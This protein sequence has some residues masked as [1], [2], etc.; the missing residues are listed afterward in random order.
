MFR[1]C[2]CG[3]T[4]NTKEEL[5]LFTKDKK[6]KYGRSNFCNTCAAAKRKK[7]VANNRNAVNRDQQDRKQN[8]KR[9]AIELKGSMCKH[10]GLEYDYTNAAVFDLH[11]LNPNEKEYKPSSLFRMSWE[12]IEKELNKCILLCSNCHRL[13]HQ[14]SF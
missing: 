5:Q 4:A 7:W 13:E 11:H 6:G 12:V 8:N 2:K 9:K 3:T 10:C 1:Q 14:P